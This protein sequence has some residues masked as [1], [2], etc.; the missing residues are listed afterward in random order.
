[1]LVS[2][3]NSLP[4][5]KYYSKDLEE[6]VKQNK[7]QVIE[8][9]KE[10]KFDKDKVIIDRLIITH[11]EIN[12]RYTVFQNDHGWSFSSSS[13]E[14]YDDSGNKYQ[15]Y[16]GTG[17]GKTWGAEGVISYHNQNKD[18]KFIKIKLDWFDRHDEIQIPLISGGTNN[19]NK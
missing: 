6:Q 17:C 7:A 14:V 4:A 5:S 16:S 19:E 13:L 10:L 18:T 3:I 12:V 15:E 11:D 1:M 9:K 2:N 8:V